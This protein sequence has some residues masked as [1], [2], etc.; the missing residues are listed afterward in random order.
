M[1]SRNVAANDLHASSQRERRHS[2][3][4][5]IRPLLVADVEFLDRGGF[6]CRLIG[7]V[8]DAEVVRAR[9]HH[10]DPPRFELGGGRL[11]LGGAR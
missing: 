2:C 8:H 9:P 5:T 10:R 7:R 3:S 6:G 4:R 11:G 1:E